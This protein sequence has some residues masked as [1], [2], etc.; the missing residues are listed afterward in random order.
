MGC[1]GNGKTSNE[2]NGSFLEDIFFF[3][4]VGPNEQ[5]GTHEKLFRPTGTFIRFFFI[6][7]LF[8]LFFFFRVTYSSYKSGWGNSE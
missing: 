2:T 8:L 5:F 6:I 1:H 4:L 7:Y 3:H